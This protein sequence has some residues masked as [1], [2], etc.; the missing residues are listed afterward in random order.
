MPLWPTHDMHHHVSRSWSRRRDALPLVALLLAH[1]G[2]AGHAVA[3]PD[4][5]T[6]APNAGAAKAAPRANLAP[7]AKADA[8]A[9]LA[10]L[11]ADLDSAELLT[12]IE[13]HRNLFQTETISL[14]A[15][16]SALGRVDLSSEQRTRLNDVAFA[17]FVN[18]PRGAMGVSYQQGTGDRLVIDAPLSRWDSAR[19]FRSGDAVI[20]I[21][22]RLVSEIEDVRVCVIARDPGE[23]ANV[24][25]ERDGVLMRAAV[26]LGKFDELDNFRSP[27]T[28]E[29][30]K[31]AWQLR[32][33]REVG[34]ATIG[35]HAVESGLTAREVSR[36]D[37]AL[38]VAILTPPRELDQAASAAGPNA[39]VG[40]A[41][42]AG[43]SGEDRA[44]HVAGTLPELSNQAFTSL[45]PR[46]GEG[47]RRRGPRQVEIQNNAQI[48][49]ALR[50]RFESD[51]KDREAA[52]AQDKARL[53][54]PGLNREQL[55]ELRRRIQSNEDAVRVL[56]L[57]IQSLREK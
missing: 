54:M 24:V 36:R 34:N 56:E 55:A 6:P 28:E 42:P 53:G 1:A 48:V 11:I 49:A 51:R 18:S 9:E 4:P 41:D 30:Y 25:F 35:E 27:I 31:R 50:E 23:M 21:D 13:A 7:N 46:R 17:R 15:M 29:N 38:R 2:L 5:V 44:L 39:V 37:A 47:N 52:I 22:G 45:D 12:R 32:L 40:I 10:R 14:S 33:E 26:R 8:A 3:A 19:V 16:I 20:S 57:Q 43:Q